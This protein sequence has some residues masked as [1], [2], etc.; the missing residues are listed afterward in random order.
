MIDE[1]RVPYP[2]FKMGDLIDPEQH[3]M[4]NL[5]IQ[6]KINDVITIINLLTDSVADGGSG[7]D[8]I[9][10]TP[11]TGFISTKL[12][13]FLEEV[14]AYL[15]S[16]NGSNFIGGSPITGVSGTTVH[17]QLTSLKSLLDVE[18]ARITALE[19]RMTTV[20]GKA[21]NTY[22]KTEVDGKDIILSG[23]ITTNETN[24]TTLTTRFNTHN[25]DDRYMTRTELVPYLQGGDTSIKIEVFTILDPNLG[26]G[27]FTYQ[28]KSGAI[29]TGSIGSNGE[30][31]FT[32]E[33]GTYTP[34][35]NQLSAVVNDTLHRSQAEGGLIEPNSFTVGLVAPETTGIKI[36]FQYFERLGVTGEHNVFLGKTAPPPTNGST[37]WFKEL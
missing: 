28:N 18:K 7:A 33:L 15:K 26:N 16:P 4:N 20:E 29:K 36:A 17:M 31:I 12:Q 24:L 25:H 13:A 34:G 37:I 23:R 27:T 30:Q 19:T 35:M 21:N 6:S 11:I 22:T 32:L 5:Y 14:I 1:L 10:L 3:D 8:Q 9:S 2:D